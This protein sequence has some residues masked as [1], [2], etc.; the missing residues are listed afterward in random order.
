MSIKS[1]SRIPIKLDLLASSTAVENPFT[2]GRT[3]DTVYHTDFY[4][5][6]EIIKRTGEKTEF[7]LASEGVH[8]NA[9]LRGHD[10]SMQMEAFLRSQGIHVNSYEIAEK[11]DVMLSQLEEEL[12][13]G[14]KN[15]AWR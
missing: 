12:L 8:A 11:T 1:K 4:G 15:N 5:F 3:A 6:S 10:F 13:I 2:V 7:S 9:Y 14:P